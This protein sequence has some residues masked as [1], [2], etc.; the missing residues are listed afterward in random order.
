MIQRNERTSVLDRIYRF[1][2]A[3][4]W[5]L[6]GVTLAYGFGIEVGGRLIARIWLVGH[7]GFV[8]P[9]ALSFIF[10]P[11]V[12]LL[13]SL[14]KFKVPRIIFSVILLLP[15]LSK[16]LYFLIHALRDDFDTSRF[17]VF[18]YGLNLHF[19]YFL[20]D[21]FYNFIDFVWSATFT[22]AFVIPIYGIITGF[23]LDRLK[24]RASQQANQS[25]DGYIAPTID[26]GIAGLHHPS[27]SDAGWIVRIPGVQEQVVDTPTLQLWA[28]QGV[29]NANTLIT[30]S[31]NQLTYPASQ[32]PS[33]FSQKTYMTAL[34]LSFFL[35]GLGVDRFYLGQTGLGVAKLLTFGGCGIWSIVDFILIAARKVTDSQG[36][37]LA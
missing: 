33:I 23:M 22:L 36:N 13:A 9:T 1:D 14:R 27:S 4:L 26:S 25:Q 28:R 30:D 34:L 18:L 8:A 10:L 2:T 16:F 7:G 12:I 11:F 32:I 15:W 20:N 6:I 17:Q 31:R 21:P 5:S 19:I 24:A 37:P 35:G 3:I 29:I